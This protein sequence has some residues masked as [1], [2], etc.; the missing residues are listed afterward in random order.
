MNYMNIFFSVQLFRSLTMS[1]I[2][3]HNMNYDVNN[4]KEKILPSWYFI[5]NSNA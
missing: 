1:I 4:I 2:L 5:F 3:K